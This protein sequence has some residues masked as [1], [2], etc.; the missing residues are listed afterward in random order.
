MTK[1]EKYGAAPIIFM[2]EQK[3][4]EWE[5]LSL[6][7]KS[8]IMSRLH[9]MANQMET[10]LSIDML[11]NIIVDMDKRIRDLEEKICSTTSK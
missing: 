1:N 2:D 8:N 9:S 6:P 7:I 3:R 4:K 11:C 5:D 10:K